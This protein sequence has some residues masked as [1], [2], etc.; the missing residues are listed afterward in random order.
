[1]CP[2]AQALAAAQAAAHNTYYKVIS[3]EPS[4]LQNRGVDNQSFQE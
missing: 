1:M 2:T 3:R 4:L